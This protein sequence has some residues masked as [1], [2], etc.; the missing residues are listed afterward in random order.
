MAQEHLLD[1]LVCPW[2][3]GGLE[4]GED[5]LA[6]RKCR[7]VYAIE[8]GIPNMLIEEAELHC[9][10]CG[11]RLEIREGAA[12]CAPCGRSWPVNERRTDLK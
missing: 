12:G 4:R 7:A 1:I 2:C 10:E 8:E 11:G 3:L 9:T 6:C 5:R